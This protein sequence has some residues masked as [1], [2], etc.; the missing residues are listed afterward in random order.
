MESE[1][2]PRNFGRIAAQTAKQVVVQ[3]IREAERN[4]I[5]EEFANREG[6]II[7][8]IVQRLSLIH[9]YWFYGHPGHCKPGIGKTSFHCQSFFGGYIGCG[10][11][12]PKN[13]GF[14]Y[15]LQGIINR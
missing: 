6:D 5:Y 12:I 2:T 9:I 3:R 1:V 8:G 11:G 14:L 10:F 15:C 4:I 7:N 13:S